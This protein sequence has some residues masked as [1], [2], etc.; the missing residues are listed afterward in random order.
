[1]TWACFHVRD[2]LEWGVAIRLM[3]TA[4]IS[5]SSS[6]GPRNSGS[7]QGRHPG[8]D[9]P[10]GLPACCCLRAARSA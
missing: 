8:Y 4:G 6:A 5:P 7:P 1:M 2:A 3:Q 10:L 9:E